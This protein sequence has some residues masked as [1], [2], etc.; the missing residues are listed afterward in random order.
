MFLKNAFSTET[1]E[2][3]FYYYNCNWCGQS[4][5]DALHHILGRV[6]NSPYN[7][8]PIHN[9]KCHIGNARLDSFENRSKLLVKTKEYLDS[10]GYRPTAQDLTFLSE[11]SKYYN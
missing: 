11:N 4:G 5:P 6:S 9:L 7:S 10:E 1:R 2:L 8:S 3:W